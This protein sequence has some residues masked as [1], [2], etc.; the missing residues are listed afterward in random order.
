MDLTKISVLVPILTISI[1]NVSPEEIKIA[2]NGLNFLSARF[3]FS[4]LDTL[5]ESR[6]LLNRFKTNSSL[7][8][9]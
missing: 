3:L 4:K 8:R 2:R 7:G 6:A 9:F 5:R 1:F